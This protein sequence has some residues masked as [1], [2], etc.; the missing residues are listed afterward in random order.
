M[1]VKALGQLL[2]AVTLFRVA[3]LDASL[4]EART[5]ETKPAT[6]I[7]SFLS[8]TGPHHLTLS[9]DRTVPPPRKADPQSFGVATSAD[10]VIVVDVASGATLFAE[11]P[12]DVRPMGSITKLMSVMVYLDSKPNL[13]ERVSLIPDDYVPGGRVYLQF[14]DPVMAESVIG[15]ALVGSDNTAAHSLFR[16]MGESEESFV[17]KMNEKSKE[18]G[19]AETHFVDPAGL[20][21]ENVSTARELAQ[22]LKAAKAY[23]VIQKY[24]EMSSY[25]VTQ[26]SGF[27]VPIA[28]TNLLLT[29]ALQ[30]GE[31]EVTGGKTGFI[32]QAGYCLAT[33]VKHEGNEVMIVVLGAEKIDDRFTDAS[34]LA[35]W[36]FDTFVWPT[37]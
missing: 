32:P 6:D 20:S 28:S 26:S 2:L 33:T 16:L 17:V 13:L 11:K 31:Y 21:S 24:M 30:N 4:L 3:P 9:S 18:L 7:S 15:A 1:I 10:S 25:R 12:D 22:I 19:L 37:L 8:V 34:A 14:N 5:D 27:S 36:A 23:P 35:V 29:S